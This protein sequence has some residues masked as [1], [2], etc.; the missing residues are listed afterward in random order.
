MNK[1]Y[2]NLIVTN[3]CG[4]KI[5]LKIEVID[6]RKIIIQP[7]NIHACQI[8]RSSLYIMQDVVANFSIDFLPT[9]CNYVINFCKNKDF[10]RSLLNKYIPN[11]FLDFEK[12]FQTP[13]R[14]NCIVLPWR[15]LNSFLINYLK[16]GDISG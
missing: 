14:Y 6:G 3:N 13:N 1:Q 15:C 16:N 5:E 10:D 8:C 11:R 4:D 9:L 7:V 12:L 2:K